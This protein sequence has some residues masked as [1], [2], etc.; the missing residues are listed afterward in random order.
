MTKTEEKVISTIEAKRIDAGMTIRGLAKKSNLPENALY[1]S[2]KR[3][4]KLTAGEL[5]AVS[6]VLHI[7]FEDYGITHEKG[8]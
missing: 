2:L 6:S 5:L 7:S 4:R 3:K 8:A 1:N